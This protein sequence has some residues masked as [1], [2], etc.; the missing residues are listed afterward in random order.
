MTVR[1]LQP[2]LRRLRSERGF[3][4]VMALGVTVCLSAVG[5]GVMAYTTDNQGWASRQKNDVTAFALW[6]IVSL[7]PT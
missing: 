7:P 6:D 4:L 2:L 3:A 1:T 5:L